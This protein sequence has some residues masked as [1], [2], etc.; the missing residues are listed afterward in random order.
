MGPCIGQWQTGADNKKVSL[1]IAVVGSE[2][3]ELLV[4]LSTPARIETRTYDQLCTLLD[5]HYGAGISNL[6]EAYKFDTRV[7][8]ANETVPEYIIA[9]RKLTI[10]CGFGD[11]AQVQSRLRNRL[12]AGVRSD[13]IK[14][15]LLSEGDDLTWTRAET[16]AATMDLA[17]RNAGKMKTTGSSEVNRLQHGG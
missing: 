2:A 6:A 15:K 14:N 4:A 12:V 17:H 9:L 7:Q 13:A 1:L 3:V 11:A 8:A 5:G 10:H 16:L